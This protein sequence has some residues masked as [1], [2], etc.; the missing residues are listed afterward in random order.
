MTESVCDDQ[1]RHDAEEIAIKSNLQDRMPGTEVFGERI[2]DREHEYRSTGRKHAQYH[3]L[4]VCIVSLHRLQ[5][6]MIAHG[7]HLCLC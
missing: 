2:H 6:R 1:E 5:R 7:E 4:L 3:V